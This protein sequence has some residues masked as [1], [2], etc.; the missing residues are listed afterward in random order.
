MVNKR[1][2]VMQ[3]MN[4]F[5]L[6]NDRKK[7]RR[8]LTFLLI[9]AV[10]RRDPSVQLRIQYSIENGYYCEMIKD[11]KRKKPT[12]KFLADLAEEMKDMA[13]QN[14]PIRKV[15]PFTDDAIRQY[16]EQGLTDK[17]QIL[18]Y[19][20]RDHFASY[21]LDGYMDYFYGSMLDTTGDLK[22]FR[23]E[24]YQHGFM[25][26]FPKKNKVKADVFHGNDKLFAAFEESAKWGETLGVRTAGEM[27]EVIASGY[28]PHVLLVQEALMEA[29]IARIAEKIVKDKKI[30][31]ILIAG[32]SSSGKTT[33]SKRLSVQLA[34]HGKMPYPISMDD[35]YVNRDDTPRDQN[36][37]FDFEALEALDIPLFND[38]M[39]NL[40][41]G[42]EVSLPTFNFKTGLREYRGNTLKLKDEDIL[43]IEGIHGL[44]EKLTSR[45]PIEAKY[46]IYISALT[47]LSID[48]HNNMS[49]ADGRLMRRMV[50][51]ARTRNTSA[52][53]TL[54]RWPSV[55]RG[56]EAN[57]FPFQEE[58]D[59]I[60]NS[61][62]IYEM[63]VLKTYVEPLLFQIPKDCEEYEVANRLLRLLDNFLPIPSEQIAINSI[64]REFIGGG[65][66]QI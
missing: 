41:N 52:L 6:E 46:K 40:L 60:F 19:W 20:R 18:Q 47:Q 65:I 3:E 22:G 39:N 11:G 16:R 32:P 9:V 56:E 10:R 14:L 57:I 55:R 38:V 30:R 17:V 33:F 5:I 12:E 62:C 48:A 23:L 64:I 4:T 61:S 1:G 2:M 58:A 31:I 53:E 37:E 44:N 24:A 45:I 59:V 13:R 7:Y 27:N 28:A 35:F 51:D 21:M 42:D 49:T 29:K 34:A 54:K 50:R 25:L 63:S 66:F 36:G 8:S 26:L 15:H 43:V